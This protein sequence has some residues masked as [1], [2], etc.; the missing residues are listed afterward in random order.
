MINGW[1][2][3]TEGEISS[4]SVR[5]PS[6][7]LTLFIDH[8]ARETDGLICIKQVK[9]SVFTNDLQKDLIPG[10][11]QPLGHA[12]IVKQFNDYNKMDLLN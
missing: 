6:Q 11:I 10:F 4:P 9:I 3:N 8:I 2:Q 5:R 7:S 12:E 1:N